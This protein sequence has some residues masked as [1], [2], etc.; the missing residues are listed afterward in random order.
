MPSGYCPETR[1][2]A[3]TASAVLPTPGMP[4]MITMLGAVPCSPVI[5]PS[6]LSR[7]TNSADSGGSV[8]GGAARPGRWPDG[9]TARSASRLRIR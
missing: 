9:R 1:R 8:S 4:S 5:S 7:P 2:A 6:S 3:R